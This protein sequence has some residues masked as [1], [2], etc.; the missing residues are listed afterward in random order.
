MLLKELSNKLGL[1]ENIML[2][3]LQCR[4]YQITN[5]MCSLKEDFAKEIE[6]EFRAG[7][8]A[9]RVNLTHSAAVN[10]IEL[11]N[12]KM[13]DSRRFFKNESEFREHIINTADDTL[14]DFIEAVTNIYLSRG[15]TSNGSTYFFIRLITA[16]MGIELAV[17]NQS[18]CVVVRWANRRDGGKQ[19]HELEYKGVV[20]AHGRGSFPIPEVLLEVLMILPTRDNSVEEQVE[21]WSAFLDVQEKAAIAKQ[22]RMIYKGR[23]YLG[24]SSVRLSLIPDVD[25]WTELLSKGKRESLFIEDSRIPEDLIESHDRTSVKI[26][27]YDKDN[28]TVTVKLDMSDEDMYDKTFNLPDQGWLCNRA[29]G[30]L[31]QVRVQKQAINKLKKNGAALTNL[32]TILYGGQELKIVEQQE[33]LPIPVEQ[34]MYPDRINEEQRLAISKALA[35]PDCFFLQGPPGTGKT[36]FIVELCYQLIQQ[37]ENVRVLISSQANLAVDNALSRLHMHP[38]IR[39]IRLGRN[40]EDEGLDFVEERAVRRWLQSVAGNSKKRLSYIRVLVRLYKAYKKYGEYL[41]D[42]IQEAQDWPRVKE[43]GEEK[44]KNLHT[45]EFVQLI[46]Q[47]LAER[48]KPILKEFYAQLI[49]LQNSL[50]SLDVTGPGEAWVNLSDS[51]LKRKWATYSTQPGPW[52][53]VK[54]AVAARCRVREGSPLDIYT[55]EVNS[56][57]QKLTYV[58]D[59]I[60]AHEKQKSLKERKIEDLRQKLS[61]LQAGKKEL[62]QVLG[63]RSLSSASK[64]VRDYSGTYCNAMSRIKQ[65]LAIPETTCEG[66]V[67]GKYNLLRLIHN[68]EMSE[69]SVSPKQ[70]ESNLIRVS[71]GFADLRRRT[72]IAIF[73]VFH[74]RALRKADSAL[75]DAISHLLIQNELGESSLLSKKVSSEIETVLHDFSKK[76]EET[77]TSIRHAEDELTR[78]D[79]FSLSPESKSIL[80]QGKQAAQKGEELG[81][82]LFVSYSNEEEV[83]EYNNIISCLHSH[84]EEIREERQHVETVLFPQTVRAVR[85]ITE[86]CVSVAKYLIVEER[87]ISEKLKKIRS[88]KTSLQNMLTEREKRY[89]DGM[90]IWNTIRSKGVPDAIDNDVPAP[91][92]FTK[93]KDKI[94]SS[95]GNQGKQKRLAATAAILKDWIS[96]L[97]SDNPEIS[98]GLTRLYKRNVNVVGATC[99]F[100]GNQKRFLEYYSEFDMVIVDEVSKATPTEL[101]VPCLL[102]KKIILVGDHKQLPPIFGEELC[103]NEAADNLGIHSGELEK[104]LKRCLFKER[105]EY[106]DMNNDSRVM[107]LKKQYRMHPH[108]MAAINQFYDGSLECGRDPELMARDRQHGLSAGSWLHSEANIVW[109]NLPSVQSWEHE[110]ADGSASRRNV[111]EAEVVISILRQIITQIPDNLDVGVTSVYAAQTR[112]I[113]EL[114]DKDEL[115]THKKNVRLK[116]VDKF[117]GMEKDIMIVSLVLNKKNVLPSRFLQTP[118]RINVAMSRARR[119]L[120][121]VGSRHNYVSLE[122]DASLSY[123]KVL[124]IARKYGRYVEVSDV[125]DNH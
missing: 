102:G 13:P 114:F 52:D 108:I 3:M 21:K 63:A 50:V 46:K 56:M 35:S 12:V 119:L 87:N 34:C 73:G 4:G 99:I 83:E 19:A 88:E 112:L 10:V 61:M 27:S 118:E 32:A 67:K 77:V 20:L 2:Q 117:Q 45:S 24:S 90:H 74:R 81:L 86:D 70:A 68:W 11:L 64:Q 47:I 49:S 101:L 60:T 37:N 28:L 29:F 80:Q 72:G 113:K 82:T 42:W 105:F 51:E 96:A 120:I 85:K 9:I 57:L 97:N 91:E 93:Y 106:L 62:L 33:L 124:D 1:S 125:L 95:V 75:N 89:S 103:F 100:T 8:M 98:E 111:K 16:E 65:A 94:I 58:Y 41:T 17:M 23:K 31:H 6:N 66:T 54:I 26:V 78:L 79:C 104:Q 14:K 18:D 22:F 15:L 55:Y 25:N 121:V 30:E 7:K 76:I 107:M 48:N 43:A 116:T 59:E 69:L 115:L 44:L 40:V 92:T 39:A 110:Q 71:E 84:I 122:H 123:G 5:T 38:K 53:A 109:V 36:T